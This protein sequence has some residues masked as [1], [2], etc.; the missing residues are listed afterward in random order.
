M[1]RGNV[2]WVSFLVAAAVVVSYGTWR[3]YT[4]HICGRSN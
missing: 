3:I 4:N 2:R 1:K